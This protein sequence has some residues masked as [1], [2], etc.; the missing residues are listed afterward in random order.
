MMR[1]L[2]YPLLCLLSVACT[3]VEKEADGVTI[4][5]KKTSEEAKSI[6]LQ[7]VND[8][9][10]RVTAF[11]SK[12]IS[13]NE[14]S[15]ATFTHGMEV[16]WSYSA[17][18]EDVVLK[19][20]ALVV[21]VQLASGRIIFQNKDRRLILAEPDGGGKTLENTVRQV[22]ESPND[23]LFYGRLPFI[24]SNTHYGILWDNA[25][26]TT[27]ENPRDSTENNP[28]R[29]KL[30][31]QS[32]SG[33][34][35]DYYF[36]YGETMD[37]LVSGYRTVTGKATIPP[38]WAMGLWQSSDS[39]TSQ[40]ALLT[41]I[42]RFRD[43]QFPIDNIISTTTYEDSRFP[44]MTKML[45]DIHAMEA[46]FAIALPPQA[47]WEEIEK[48]IFT[49]G[50]DAWWLNNL[51]D[52][53]YA[54][55]IYK[56]QEKADNYHRSVIFDGSEAPALQQ[57]SVITRLSDEKSSWED[58]KK[59]IST[60]ASLSIAGTPYWALEPDVTQ[61]SDST[62]EPFRELYT[63]WQQFSAFTPVFRATH[64][65]WH[66]APEGHAAYSSLLYYANLRYRLM[67]YIYSL[68]GLCY[69][70]DYT[71]MRPPVMDFPHDAEVLN[72]D[73]QYMF[74]PALMVCP[75]YREAVAKREVYFPKA[76][77]WYDVYSGR[78]V[79]GGLKDTVTA[80]Y[81]HIPLFARAGA[82]VPMGYSL[83]NTQEAQKNLTLFVYAG[84]DGKFTLYE[85]ENTN[86]NYL[87]GRFTQ[88]PL[89]YNHAEMKLTIG[90]RT[91]EFQGMTRKRII[92]VVF[93]S[94][95]HPMGIDSKL[96]EKNSHT[97]LYNGDERTV[98]F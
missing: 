85:D 79:N 49:K 56:G 72:V 87:K 86:N 10:I 67:P 63:R 76:P 93:V 46:Q 73:D 95:N 75:V 4:Y 9:V 62:L 14:T 20:S 92:T 32:A 25:T 43:H 81:D 48:N 40:N 22:F 47:S 19:T 18:N 11:P 27:F 65:P 60:G 41:G 74:G 78:A 68:A 53:L 29:N 24:V 83:Q 17:S 1:K 82:I 64:E 91:G 89:T 37:E 5:L 58:L 61:K 71:L 59:S 36:I 97:I 33:S 55:S 8:H 7:V 77:V 26:E 66:I 15:L 96:S 28:D 94:R 98:S 13:Q 23:E 42:N 16:G 45:E 52:A 35:L 38:Q 50:V 31:F 69:F 39:Y 3:V 30:A 2:T 12:I 57:Y 6:H 84:A 44:D 34:L 90:K 88:I 54:K 51:T 21:S 70:D 80:P